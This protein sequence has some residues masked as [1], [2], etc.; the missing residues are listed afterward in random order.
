MLDIVVVTYNSRK[1]IEPCIT[2]IASSKFDLS[3]VS[4]Y[5][6]DNASTDNTLE[7]LAEERTKYKKRFASFCVYSNETNVGFGTGNNIAAKLGKGEYILFLNIDTIIYPDTLG[8][9][10]QAIQASSDQVGMWELRQYPFEH[11]KVYDPLTGEVSWCSGACFVIERNLFEKLNGF[12]ER[13]FMYAEDVDLSWR[14]RAEKR[15]I[16]Y[17]PR[18]TIQHFCY[19]KE[20]EIKPTQ[21]VYSLAY[22]LLLRLKFGSLGAI[23]KGNI[24]F[25]AQIIR[26]SPLPGGRRRLLEAWGRCIPSYM[27]AVG[28]HWNHRDKLKRMTYSFIGWDY[29]KTRIG[30]FYKNFR[31]ETQKKVSVLVRTCGRPEVLRET[32]QSLRRQTYPNIEI[33][34]VEDGEEKSKAMIERDFPDLNIVYHATQEKKGRCVAGNLALQ[35]A[36][37]DYFNFLDD[38][39]LFYADHVETLVSELEMHPENSVAYSLAFD[40][41]IHVFSQSPYRYEIKAYNCTVNEEFNRLKLLHHN[42]FPIQAVMFKRE[43]FEELGGFDESLDVLEDWDLWVRYASKYAFRFVK[44]TTSIYRVPD[45]LNDC[46]NRQRKLDEA[47]TSVRNKHKN[48]IPKWTMEQIQADCLALMDRK[49]ITTQSLLLRKIKERFQKL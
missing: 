39:D 36:T 26:G 8:E 11:P 38:D 31:P 47:L 41:P 32:L 1:W 18:A 4:L 23:L 34:I 37:G 5:V 20:M 21:Y 46:A 12:D 16:Q 44:K 6:I 15:I 35:L 10:E 19:Q 9:I 49:A 33:V 29:E 25:F 27:A 42:L 40:T 28:W 7:E 24:L 30:A 14:V 48:Y 13:I 17:I 45:E 2:S 43:V 22:N 3:K